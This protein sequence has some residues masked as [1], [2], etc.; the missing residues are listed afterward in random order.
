MGGCWPVK[1]YEKHGGSFGDIGESCLTHKKVQIV[2]MA[3]SLY[4][5]AVVAQLFRGNEEC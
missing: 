5:S 3:K 1:L 4:I 2:A